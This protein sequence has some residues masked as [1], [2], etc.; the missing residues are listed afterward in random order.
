MDRWAVMEPITASAGA[1]ETA[2]RGTAAASTA[3]VLRILALN[4]GSP[5]R[6]F[7]RPYST[8]RER[9]RGFERSG[10]DGRAPGRGGEERGADRPAQVAQR[11]DVH[12]GR[13]LVREQV[14]LH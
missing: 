12:V 3:I 9:A 2:R 5:W 13:A 10:G 14:R 8:R 4:I 11:G 7:A 1:A 6:W